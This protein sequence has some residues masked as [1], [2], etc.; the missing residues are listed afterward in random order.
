MFTYIFV[1]VHMWSEEGIFDLSRFF[2]ACQHQFARSFLSSNVDN[3][4]H[5][6]RKVIFSRAPVSFSTFSV[7]FLR[8]KANFCFIASFSGTKNS[9][10]WKEKYTNDFLSNTKTDDDYGKL[11]TRCSEI[12]KKLGTN[13]YKLNTKQQNGKEV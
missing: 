12:D 9:N 5:S 10:T 3:L 1:V 7:P 6:S 4:T 13:K 11:T 2:L 8:K